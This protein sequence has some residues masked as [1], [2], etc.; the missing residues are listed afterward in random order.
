M[1]EIVN[2]V[3]GNRGLGGRVYAPS[4]PPQKSPSQGGMDAY[5]TKKPIKFVGFL[6]GHIGEIIALPT[7]KITFP[8]GEMELPN[9]P[10]AVRT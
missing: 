10:F 9:S 2:E 8:W 4:T 7:K 3:I 1:Q 5:L 6:A